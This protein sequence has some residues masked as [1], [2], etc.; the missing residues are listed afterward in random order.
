MVYARAGAGRHGSEIWEKEYSAAK[1]LQEKRLQ[2]GEFSNEYVKH[3]SS[4]NA[5]FTR[6][7]GDGQL[8]SALERNMWNEGYLNEDVAFVNAE[9]CMRAFYNKCKRQ[10]NTNFC[11]DSVK[12]LVVENGAA[13]GIVLESGNKLVADLV[14]LA[15]G[16]WSNTLLDL[17]SQIT[18]TG[19]EVA[20]LK[21]TPEMEK[22]YKNMP[23][24]G[25]NAARMK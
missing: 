14:I 15:T 17:R 11:F 1:L 23:V 4:H 12:R 21:L 2:A 5:L 18:A 9:E 3:L 8:S 20:W 25:I 7:N 19:H 16:A 10:P 6:V 22:R 13:K 24:N